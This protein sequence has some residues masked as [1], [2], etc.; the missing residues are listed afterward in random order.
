MTLAM[1][2][3][4]KQF[5]PVPDQSQEGIGIKLFMVSKLLNVHQA[6]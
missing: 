4:T 5:I 3:Y 6:K 1:Y 2:K